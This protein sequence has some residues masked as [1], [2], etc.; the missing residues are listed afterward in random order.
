MDTRLEKFRETIGHRHS[1]LVCV[2]CGS[3]VVD[4][5]TLKE[6]RCNSCGNTLPWDGTKFTVARVGSENDRSGTEHDAKRA[7]QRHPVA[8]TT[9]QHVG[10]P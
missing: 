1:I 6:L 3:T 9:G 7:F 5:N 2:K 4:Q 8:E 10:M